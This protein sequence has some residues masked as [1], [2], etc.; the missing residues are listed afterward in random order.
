MTAPAKASSNGHHITAP[1]PEPINGIVRV[2][3][4][5]AYHLASLA[6][7]AAYEAERLCSVI[8]KAASSGYMREPGSHPAAELA[9]DP[10]MA[11]KADEAV[12]CL[13]TA[14]MYL[15][16]LFGGHLTA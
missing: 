16:D 13:A 10:A 12:A 7:D 8:Q 11:G 2:Q 5:E 4:A 9:A 1:A 3:E 15:T 14:V 6:R